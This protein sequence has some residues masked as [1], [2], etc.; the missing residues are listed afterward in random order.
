METIIGLLFIL[1]PLI[2]K[3]IGK[4]F[5]QSGKAGTARKFREMANIFGEDDT[6]DGEPVAASLPADTILSPSLESGPVPESEPIPVRVPE[7]HTGHNRGVYTKPVEVIK[8]VPVEEDVV[9]KEK[10]DPKKLVI[11]SE[12]MKRKF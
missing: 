3:L 11:Y 7:R 9:K 8:P 12:I 1:L 4:K 6:E 10:I 5:E 2:F